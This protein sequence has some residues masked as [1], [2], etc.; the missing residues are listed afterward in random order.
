MDLDHSHR[1]NIAHH[2][3]IF[4]TVELAYQQR[5]DGGVLI[6]APAIAAMTDKI[7]TICPDLTT[8]EC[9]QFCAQ[10]SILRENIAKSLGDN[11]LKAAPKTAHYLSFGRGLDSD[12]VTSQFLWPEFSK[13]DESVGVLG[14]KFYLSNYHDLKFNEAQIEAFQQGLQAVIEDFTQKNFGSFIPAT[15]EEAESV[16]RG[17]RFQLDKTGLERC[18]V[19]T[20]TL[21]L[22][23]HVPPK[24]PLENTDGTYSRHH[25]L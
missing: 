1:S 24:P 15:P 13:V 4:Y 7:R 8:K 19:V 5:I 20:E 9:I 14:L 10:S 22:H 12:K 25:T 3:G 6:P 17:H 16:E 2:F 21:E 23:A 18:R 11:L